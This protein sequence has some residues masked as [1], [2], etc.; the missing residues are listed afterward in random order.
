MLDRVST[1]A[2]PCARAAAERVAAAVC[3]GA[4]TVAMMADF[5]RSAHSGGK[6]KPPGGA[7]GETPAAGGA[8]VAQSAPVKPEEEVKKAAHA[9][10]C[11]DEKCVVT[12]G[13]MLTFVEVTH[14][15][16]AVRRLQSEVQV[17]FKPA[18]PRDSTALLSNFDIDEVLAR[19]AGEPQ[20]GA[21]FNCPFA[22]MD[23]DREAY[24]FGRVSLPAVRARK[25]PQQV[26]PP[27][28]PRARE[29]KR[30]CDT[31]ACVLNTD[32]SSGPGKHWVCAFADMRGLP[33]PARPWTV[34]Y[35]NS[36]GNAPPRAVT[37]W[38]ARASD[39][40]IEALAAEGA[41][42]AAR[43]VKVASVTKVTHQHSKTE[44]GLYT[45]FYIRARLE[46][47][48][49]DMFLREKVTDAMMTEFRRHVFS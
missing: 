34:E 20:F 33:T 21:F 32:T 24:L 1:D 5:N 26:K 3:S 17:A 25:V 43:C 31:F 18:G 19:W 35:F 12:S 4:E 2:T 40:L 45:L 9:L 48:P 28:E 27:G 14:G 22:M 39:E 23:F 47:N 30:R 37:K 15:P 36:A 13:A 46:G 8:R 44:C 11:D 10:G 42:D 41:A 16:A 7:E 6:K 38:L 49:A 29:V